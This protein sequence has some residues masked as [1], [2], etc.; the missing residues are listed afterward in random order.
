[1]GNKTERKISFNFFDII[2]IAVVILLAAGFIFIKVRGG[3]EGGE[4]PQ[5]QT[6]QYKI[7]ITNVAEGTEALIQP[8]DKIVDKVKKQDMGTVVSSRFYPQQKSAVNLE[9]GDLLFTDVP[10]AYAAEITL[11]AE[12]SESASAFVTGGGYEVKVGT[13]VSILAPGYGGSGYVVDIV[14]GE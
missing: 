14:R 10:G 2:I 13:Q 9:T 5:M 1:M 6:V 7:E 12:C 11:E 4:I 8:G 3:G